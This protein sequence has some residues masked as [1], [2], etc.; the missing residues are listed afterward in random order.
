MITLTWA[1]TSNQNNQ[2]LVKLNHATVTKHVL[3]AQ[4]D[5]AAPGAAQQLLLEMKIEV[6]AWADPLWLLH[7]K[8]NGLPCSN[9]I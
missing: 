6:R 8:H 5:E 4:I 1:S 7:R 2:Q 3:V 9:M